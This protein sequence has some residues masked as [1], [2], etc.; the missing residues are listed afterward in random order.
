MLDTYAL[1]EVAFRDGDGVSFAG[2]PRRRCSRWRGR[3][4]AS[5]RR[6]SRARPPPAP[7]RP[8]PPPHPP[9][10]PFSSPSPPRSRSPNSP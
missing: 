5:G 2:L 1:H 6:R 10:R 8:P 3:R 7:T 4:T 9:H